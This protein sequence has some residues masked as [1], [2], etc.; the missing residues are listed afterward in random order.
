MKHRIRFMACLLA[1]LMLTIA[2][3]SC[4]DGDGSGTTAGTTTAEKGTTTEDP[5]ATT[6]EETTPEEAATPEEGTTPAEDSTPAESDTEI[7]PV[8]L[9]PNDEKGVLKVMSFNMRYRNEKDGVNILDNRLPKI[10]DVIRTEAPD[11]IGFQE[12]EDATLLWLS[13]ML[14]DY[15]IIGHGRNANYKGE[16]TPIAY[17]KDRFYLHGFEVTWLSDT[18][19]TPGTLL[20]GV[21]Q[22]ACPRMI[23]HAELLFLDTGELISFYNV[24]ADHKSDTARLEE[25]KLLMKQY[26]ADP[27]RYVITG[28]FNAQPTSTEIR[29]LINGGKAN[30]LKDLSAN[31]KGTFHNWGTMSS[32][33]DYILSTIPATDAPC[34]AVSNK[35]GYY[36]DHSAIVVCLD[37]NRT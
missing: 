12:V 24:H 34:R 25:V 15:V 10:L 26:Q 27:N 14:P 23:M 37:L 5:A 7:P 30:G 31:L 11:I 6:P 8:V 16:G 17:R 3:V 20:E 9:E 1:L 4:E 18:P 2:V 36:S 19:D 28:D 29:A 32:K 22:S 33:L 13:E 35:N 21:G